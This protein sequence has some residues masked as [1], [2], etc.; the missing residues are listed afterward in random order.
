MV[1]TSE[2]LTSDDRRTTVDHNHRRD[3]YSAARPSRRNGLI[4]ISCDTEYL[5]SAERL[6]RGR[7]GL[8]ASAET[9]FFSF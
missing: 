6:R 3:L 8:L 5:A 1:V 2:A 7:A 4:T 9:C